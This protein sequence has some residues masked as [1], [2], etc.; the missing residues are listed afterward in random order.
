MKSIY[1]T[2]TDE[3][4][5]NLVKIK[6][7]ITWHDFILKL[8]DY[9]EDVQTEN[10]KEDIQDNGTGQSI[11]NSGDAVDGISSGDA[12]SGFESRFGSTELGFTES[13][14]SEQPPKEY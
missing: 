3:E 8:E 10:I 4:H 2:F 12:E 1:E 9:V 7:K 14:L 13:G 6:G 5:E 11:G